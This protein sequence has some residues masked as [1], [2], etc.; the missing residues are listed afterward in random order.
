MKK[1]LN[2]KGYDFL[3]SNEIKQVIDSVD[4]GIHIVDKDGITVCYNKTCE[5]IEGIS[6]NWIIGKNV[7]ELV[8]RGVY[9]ESVSL[10]VIETGKSVRKSQRVNNKYIFSTGEPIY[11]DKELIFV[12]VSVMDMTNIK[13]VMAQY[14]ELK[15]INNRIQNELNLIN[16]INFGKGLIISKSK[17]MEDIKLLALRVS[18][19]NSTVL[20]EGESGVGKGVLARFIHENSYRTEGPFIKVDCASLPESLIES[21]LFGYVEGA[22]TGA[23]KEGK[24]GLIQLADKGTL[25]LDEIG[26]LPL[27]LQIKLLGLIQDKVF[28]KIGGTTDINIDARIIAAT[29]RDLEEML[30]EGLFRKDL[31]YRLKVVPIILPPLRDRRDD[32]V[33]LVNFFL[34]KHNDEYGFGKTISPRVMGLLV[35]Y[36]WPGNIR[37]LE[38]E[39]ERLVV[40]SENLV[41]T[42]ED[43]IGS[44]IYNQK[45][46]FTDEKKSFKENVIEYEKKLLCKYL[47]ISDDI[48]HL[49]EKTGLEESTLRK[50]SKRIG[51]KLKF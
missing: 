18:T 51:I 3:Y 40:T 22:F 45:D 14:Y 50:K 30:K 13:S 46:V 29:N 44:K 21:E 12:V 16:A 8:E 37:E 33:P 17:V 49:S 32:I 19:V 35:S 34:N 48:H 26:E 4:I 47:E 9:S 31:Y 36:D 10:K 11:K 5:E 15:E 39:I 1:L 20:I 42:E 6:S 43:I 23:R 27:N 38:N 28:Q 25:F 41:I 24:V 7:K 2:N